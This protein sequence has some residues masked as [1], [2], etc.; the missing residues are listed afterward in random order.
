MPAPPERDELAPN[1]KR[2][3]AV[4]FDEWKAPTD[5][6]FYNIITE[7]DD[8]DTL[9]VTSIGRGESLVIY[10]ANG[11]A[12]ASWEGPDHPTAINIPGHE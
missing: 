6:D 8:P 12:I 11:N 9:P 7:F 1:N 5:P 10:D 2:Y 3:S 4:K